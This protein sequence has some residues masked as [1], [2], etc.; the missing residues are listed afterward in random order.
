M[1]TLTKPPATPLITLDMNDCIACHES[2]EKSQAA[3]TASAQAH[4]IAA[5]SL[6]TDCNS[7]HR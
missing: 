7:C 1:E 4:P 5:R 6:L 2:R 3:K